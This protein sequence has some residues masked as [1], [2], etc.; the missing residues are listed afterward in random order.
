M[1]QSLALIVF[2]VHVAETMYLL[3]SQVSH[4]IAFQTMLSFCQ[5]W[6]D[7]HVL[8]QYCCAMWLG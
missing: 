3:L 8:F 2:I 1:L 6:L 7:W 5:S 4:I